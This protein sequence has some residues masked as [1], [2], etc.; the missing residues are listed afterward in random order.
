MTDDTWTVQPAQG[1]VRATLTVPGDKSIS[2]RAAMLSALATGSS[3]IEGFLA[4]EDCLNTLKA[5][6]ALGAKVVR[7]GTCVTIEGTGGAFV[8]P[9]DDLDLG[10]SGTGMRLLAGLLAGQ[11]LDCT[12]T[13]DASLRSRPMGRIQNPLMA[14]GGRIE[15]LGGHGCAPL[16]VRGGRLQAIA[17]RL[18]MASAQVKSAVLLAGMTAQGTTRVIE[19]APTRDHTERML[20]AMGAPLRVDGLTIELDGSGGAPVVLTARDWQVPGDISSAAFW[21]TAAACVSGSEVTVKGVGLNPRRTALLDVL[22]RMGAE[23][24][25]GHVS[26]AEWEPQADV[27]VRGRTLSSTDIAGLEIPNLIDEL[28]LVA[29]AGA[30]AVG[31]TRIRDAAELRV[32]ESDRIA[33]VAEGLRAFGV[34]VSEQEDGMA[35]VGGSELCGGATIESHG[36]HRIAMAMAILGLRAKGPTTVNHVACVATS[37][38]GFEDDLKTVTGGA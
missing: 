13:G 19:P 16:R 12:M 25:I 20:L 8:Q 32:K 22:R 23:V 38:P 33:C 30:C 29:V 5:V 17:Y 1:D 26:H 9:S 2:H 18:P 37:Y 4:S 34:S 15:A 14:M 6:S 11:P 24:R 28:P 21:F 3:R 7:R 36:D 35:V 10:N 31:V 27:T